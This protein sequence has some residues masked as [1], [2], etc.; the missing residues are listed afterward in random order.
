MR[1][2]HSIQ[3]PAHLPIRLW[4]LRL[5]LLCTLAL[6]SACAPA[7]ANV[8]TPSPT[9]AIGDL[10]VTQAPTS[11]RPT[12]SPMAMTPASSLATPSP[13]TR[14]ATPVYGY[15]IVG[16]Y[17][18][19]PNAFTQGLVYEDG[20]LYEGTGLTLGQS[21]L[22]RVA[23]KTGMVLKIH[24]LESEYFGEGIS[25]VGDRIW[26]LT[27]Q[28]HVAFLYDKETFEQL[29]TVPYPTEGWG[30]SY[31]G[32]HLIM[33]DGSAMLCFRDP[34]TFELMGRVAVY[35]DQGPVARLNELEYIDGQVFANVWM[36]NRIA[37]IDPVTGRVNA[38]LDLAGL[39]DTSAL[40]SQVD[41]LNG[42]A[43]DAAGQ[44]LFVTGKWWPS[45]FEIE[46]VGDDK[47]VHFPTTSQQ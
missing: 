16:E 46:V 5:A 10:R 4:Q 45:L 18:H 40:P 22:R 1:G 27:W 6:A 29:D 7:S 35:D 47:T 44:R 43:Y 33:S 30:L 32:E 25:V 20:V 28:N 13:S 42:I 8:A 39:L 15:R 23:L 21:S 19:D 12:S 38:W 34:D 17:P 31:D 37:I 3:G 24:N 9:T 36:T 41:V 11:P 14:E 26:Q 2:V